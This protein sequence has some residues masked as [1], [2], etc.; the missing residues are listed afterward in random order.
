MNITKRNKDRKV[1]WLSVGLVLLIHVLVGILLWVV[2]L[3]LPDMQEESGLPV[4]LGN[5]GNLDTD[6][7]FTEIEAS[8]FSDA[9]LHS[10][11]ISA[12]PLVTQ[13][14]EE[15]VALESGAKSE[16]LQEEEHSQPSEDE[17]RRQAEERAAAEANKLM[18]NLFGGS[19]TSAETQEEY[20]ATE[21]AAGSPRGNSTEG[22][23]TGTGGFGTFDLSGR[24]V[25]A[26]GLQRPAYNVQEE[27]R[28]VVTITVSPSGEVIATSINKRSNTTNAQLRAA[29][30]EAARRTRF[31]AASGP[32]NQTGT[33]TYYFRLR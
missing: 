29:A 23:V 5:M 1:D 21:G 17:L 16:N 15:T 22:H 27:G 2:W 20:S 19:Q 7:D 12:M 25:D 13:N 10:E 28:V 6:Y 30:E 31:T 24:D 26:N 18:Q 11:A 14:M 4:V 33:I 32:D 3:D 8:S 9:A